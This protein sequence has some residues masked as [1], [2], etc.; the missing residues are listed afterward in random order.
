MQAQIS[1]LTRPRKRPLRILKARF[2]GEHLRRSNPRLKPL[3]SGQAK[4]MLDDASDL[5]A[6]HPPADK[7]PLS[8]LLQDNW[9]GKVCN[10]PLP[11]LPS[12][13]ISL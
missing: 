3:L 1:S 7:D 2:G 5:A 13:P 10:P 9:P 4:S 12:L 8:Q 6:L 11:P